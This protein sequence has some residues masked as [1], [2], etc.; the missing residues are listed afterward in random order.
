MKTPFP[1]HPV[2]AAAAVL[3]LA[4]SL[5][6]ASPVAAAEGAPGAQSAPGAKLGARPGAASTSSA[7]RAVTTATRRSR[8]APRGPSP[9]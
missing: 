4:G 2:P 7:P 8:W 6:A 3:A 9:T 1:V 5:F